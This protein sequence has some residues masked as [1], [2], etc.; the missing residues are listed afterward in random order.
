MENNVENVPS[1][2]LPEILTLDPG[3]SRYTLHPIKYPGIY[4]FYKKQKNCFWVHD[5]IDYSADLNDWETLDENERYFI[6]HIL[7]FFAGADGIV[8]ENLVS[9]FSQEVKPIEASF[10][11]AFQ[12]MMENEHN[13][14]YSMLIETFIKNPDRKSTL[15]NAIDNIPC[16]REKAEWA[17]KWMNRTRS[18]ASRLIAF[19]VVEG[20]FFSGS[21]CAIFWL[22][23]RGK[24][25]NS[26][27]KSNELISRDEGLH[28]D[29]AVH[30]YSYITNRLSTEEVYD[31]FREAVNIESKFITA[32]IPCRMI[33]M[34]D[35]L[36]IE[37]IQFV[38]DRLI[39]Q[40]GYPKLY[41]MSNPFD[42]MNM[43][44]IDSKSSFFESRVTEYQLAS[45]K[46]DEFSI[47]A[48]F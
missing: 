29:F 27:G 41:G 8:L 13:A 36:M 7:A 46:K 23:S 44:S 22:K 34:N 17:K 47:N 25:I 16:V 9:N 42:F 28:T 38:S 37:Y 5:E 6:E 21:F 19:A 20:V 39:V 10:A 31:I 18:F 35:K 24:M 30:L 40:L 15:L 14:T 1:K 2:S 3:N 26:L 45:T 48:D 43:I 4:E 32:S 11:Y 12:A 33:G